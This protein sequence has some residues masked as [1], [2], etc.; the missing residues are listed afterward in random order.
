MEFY[1]QYFFIYSAEQ[2]K[3]S[4]QLNESNCITLANSR[5]RA[6]YQPSTSAEPSPSSTHYLVKSSKCE[7]EEND[8]DVVPEYIDR[9]KIFTDD[10]GSSDNYSI[11]YQTPV[12]S[13][14]SGVPSQTNSNASTTFA[15]NNVNLPTN[16]S[17]KSSSSH[18]IYGSNASS[19]S[20]HS[21]GIHV[22][23]SP[24]DSGIVDYESIIRD[25]EN[26]LSTVRSTMEQNEEI[27][28]RVYQEKERMWKEQLADLK[29]K[30][31][32]S[33]QGESALRQQIQRCNEQRDQFQA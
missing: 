14:Q 22:T 2:Y 21:S 26:E 7:N 20:R 11:L 28:I 27:I 19:G 25:K 18:H 10:S 24:S 12:H 29:Q 4:S 30:L 13:N 31:Q 8:Y 33:Q 1:K 5:P 23:P 32:A 17:K 9:E 6:I 15:V 16:V 3:R